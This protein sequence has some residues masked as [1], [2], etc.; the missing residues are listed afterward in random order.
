MAGGHTTS[1]K[2]ADIPFSLAVQRSVDSN[3]GENPHRGE[4]ESA[5]N[6]A[7]HT[8]LEDFCY[9][10]ETVILYSIH[11]TIGIHDTT[12]TCKAKSILTREEAFELL[13]K[14]VI[15]TFTSEHS[16]NP[17]PTAW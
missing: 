6:H 12:N 15:N 8:V 7:V 4:H 13:D 10:R 16:L 1:V 5:T 2:L 17:S 14:S 3:N 11:R 9:S